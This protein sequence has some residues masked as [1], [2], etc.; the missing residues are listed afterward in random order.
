LTAPGSDARGRFHLRF[1]EDQQ[2][3]PEWTKTLCVSDAFL[4]STSVATTLSTNEALATENE[5]VQVSPLAVPDAVP[6][7]A[8][9]VYVNGA[10][11]PL[12]MAV[13]AHDTL[14]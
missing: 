4:P 6:L 10:V 8:L 14:G 9:Q 3:P 5:P 12:G 7:M 1:Q 11:P 2:L 13:Y